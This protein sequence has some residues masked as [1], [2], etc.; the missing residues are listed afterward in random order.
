MQRMSTWRSN[1][2]HLQAPGVLSLS[3]D[4]HR[5]DNCHGRSGRLGAVEGEL[6]PT[7]RPLATSI[8]QWH[9]TEGWLGWR[10]AESVIVDVYDSMSSRRLIGA[11]AC[12]FGRQVPS[13]ETL[14]VINK[15][16]S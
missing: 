11:M 9:D 1:G 4:G 8:P 14:M 16:L 12:I 10:E 5:R 2:L 15:R 3:S 13:V 7:T 6:P